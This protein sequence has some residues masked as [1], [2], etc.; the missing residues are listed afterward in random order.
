M[1]N[2]Q[3]IS[4]LIGILEGEGSL[5]VDKR[6]VNSFKIRIS[7]SDLDIINKCTEILNKNFIIHN[8]YSFK[9]VANRKQ[10]HEI[11]IGTYNSCQHLLRVFGD[12]FQCR[13]QEF[14]DKSRSSTTTRE[15]SLTS[16]FAWLIGIFEAEGCFQLTTNVINNYYRPEISVKNTNYKIIEKIQITLLNLNIPF[17]VKDHKPTTPR[18]PWRDVSIVGLKRCQKFLLATKGFWISD[19]YSIKANLLL[20]YCNTR[21]EMQIKEPNTERQEQI[22]RMLRMVI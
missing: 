17:Y 6:K 12:K 20:E 18:K 10:M 15:T 5:S 19:K 22:F 14:L 4:W 16:D 11:T 8:V 2:Q 9:K 3:E 13:I 21:L 1:D 7:N